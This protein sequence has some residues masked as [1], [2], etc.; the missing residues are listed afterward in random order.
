LNVE[1]H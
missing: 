1:S